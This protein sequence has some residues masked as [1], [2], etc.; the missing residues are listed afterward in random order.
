MTDLCK[1]HGQDFVNK[2]NENFYASRSLYDEKFYNAASNRIYFCLIHTA[3]SRALENEVSRD[4][5][6]RQK[7]TTRE[8]KPVIEYTI[9]KSKIESNLRGIGVKDPRKFSVLLATAKSARAKADY[10]PV[11]VTMQELDQ[12]LKDL[13]NI[14][15]SEGVLSD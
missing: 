11:K 4:C 12:P 9:D 5:Y 14:L 2:A 15:K 6:L 7:E 1:A 8:K 3:L 13:E 10:F